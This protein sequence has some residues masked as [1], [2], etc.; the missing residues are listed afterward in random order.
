M[1]AQR[2]KKS[3]EPLPFLTEIFRFEARKNVMID[4]TPHSCHKL[5]CQM[6]LMMRSGCSKNK[7]KGLNSCPFF[8]STAQQGQGGRM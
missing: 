8:A 7:K 5:I 3:S 4:T 2:T 6:S 1:D